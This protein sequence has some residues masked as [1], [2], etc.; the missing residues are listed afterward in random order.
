MIFNGALNTDIAVIEAL[1]CLGYESF[2][3]G[4]INH[5]IKGNLY[6]FSQTYMYP[7]MFAFLGFFFRRGM[8]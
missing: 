1:R 4:H 2:T 7:F 5:D 3:F 8:E 6:E